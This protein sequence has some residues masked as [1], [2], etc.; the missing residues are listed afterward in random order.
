MCNNVAGGYQPRALFAIAGLFCTV[1]QVRRDAA[2]AFAQRRLFGQISV[3]C[4]LMKKLVDCWFLN[5]KK[6][7][8]EGLSICRM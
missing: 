1:R 8:T 6:G 3:D 7:R 4:I 2:V 5:I